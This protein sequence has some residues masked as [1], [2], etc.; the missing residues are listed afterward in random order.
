M[1]KKIIGT[2]LIAAVFI[3]LLIFMCGLKWGLIVA[4]L[5]A[6]FIV[7]VYLVID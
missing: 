4:A 3:I 6:M 5:C 7:G 2:I 1:I